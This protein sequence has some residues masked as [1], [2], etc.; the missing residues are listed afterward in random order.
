MVRQRTLSSSLVKHE[1]S[2]G[3]A[4][5]GSSRGQT[6]GPL[7]MGEEAGASPVYTE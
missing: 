2:K 4:P 6:M 5:R 3:R 7:T 1:R